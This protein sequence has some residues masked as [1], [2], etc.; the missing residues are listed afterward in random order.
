MS[1]PA[2]IAFPEESVLKNC[3]DNNP[4]MGGFMYAQNGKVYIQKGYETWKDFKSALDKARAKTG[5]RIPYVCH[6]RISTQG[7][8]KACCQ[9]FPLSGNM[10]ALKRLKYDANIGVAHNGILHLTSDGSKEYSDTMKFITD[11]LVNIIRNY[12]WYKD[13]RTVTLIE[14]LIEGSRFAILDKQ[15][16]CE[17]LGKGWIE[18]KG[19]YYSNSTYS[20]KKYAYSLPM[21]GGGRYWDDYYDSEEKRW[22][23]YWDRIEKKEQEEKK[24]NSPSVEEPEW[25]DPW[26]R[27]YN[28]GTCQYEFSQY[29][30]PYSEEDDDSYCECCSRFGTCPYTCAITLRKASGYED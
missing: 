4:D 24:N 25:L 18:D 1:K 5:D 20:Y 6:F 16:H 21:Y 17:L 9:P 15:G 30:C 23:D 14:N 11:Y 10:K 8:D 13:N 3:W 22:A 27:Y 12:S 2:N 29:Y 28:N 19:C 7:F 26:A